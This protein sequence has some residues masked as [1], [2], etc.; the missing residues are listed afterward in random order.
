MPDGLSACGPL[1]SAGSC[2]S[3]AVSGDSRRLTGEDPECLDSY[4]RAVSIRGDAGP[5]PAFPGGRG[6]LRGCGR[7]CRAWHRK[8]SCTDTGDNCLHPCVFSSVK[9]KQLLWSSEAGARKAD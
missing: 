2:V 6:P 7:G 1:A 4:H 3:R 5:G 9:E 8:V